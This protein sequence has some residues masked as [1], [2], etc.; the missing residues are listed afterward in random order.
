VGA[1]TRASSA[2][3][4]RREAL[5]FLALAVPNLA[6]IGVFTYRPL[7]LN[8]YY[9]TL[10]WTLG[11]PT[12]TPIGLANYREFFSSPDARQ[13]LWVTAVF[14]VCTVVGTMV[15]GLLVALGLNKRVRGA[16]FA[17]ATVFSPFVLSGV[18]VGLAWLYIFDPTVGAL[19]AVLRDVGVRSPEWFNNPHLSLM[20]VI[21]VYIW[22]NLGYAAVI[23]LAG[24]QAVPRDLMDAAAVDGAGAWRRFRHVTLP[25]LSPTTFFILV[26]SMLSSLQ[27]FD[28][29]RAMTLLGLGTNKLFFE[30][31]LQAF[32]GYNLSGFSGMLSTVLFAILV[33]L[34]L[35]QLG[36]LERKVHYR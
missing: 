26:T 24:L 30:S 8:I 16:G 13:V 11:S 19:G 14:T 5:V 29:L 3:R 18:G 32:C 7:F 2:R 1:T 35:V 28:I 22:K 21:I 4:R 36:V 12:A 23:Y 25:L 15:L 33:V 34:T 17:R 6:L 27:A 10:D 9:S 20:M 31:Y